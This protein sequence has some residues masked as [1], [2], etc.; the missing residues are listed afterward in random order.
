M[1][2][3]DLAKVDVVSSNLITRSIYFSLNLP[4]ENKILFRWSKFIAEE[5]QDE[6]ENKMIA[7]DVVY[8]VESL[9]KRKR[10]KLS[11]YGESRDEMEVLQARFGGGVTQVNPEDWQPLGV[12]GKDLLLR[13]RDRIVVTGSSDLARIEDLENANPGRTVLSFPPQLAF[14]TGSHPTSAGCLR[15]MVDFAKECEQTEKPWSVLDVGCG[16]GILAIAAAKLGAEKVVAIELDSMALEYAVIN[17]ERHGVADRIEFIDGDGIA[18]LRDAKN[19]KFD[20]ITANLFSELLIESMPLFRR[21][22][23]EN[24]AGQIILSGFL[25]SQAKDVIDESKQCGVAL[26]KFIRRGNWVVGAS[27]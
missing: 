16:S 13:I 6:W 26:K 22:L 14:G 17:A 7:A 12:E 27:D 23:T 20:L 3:R 10:L 11:S 2:E 25:T 21:N 1:V 4:V 9:V 15:L 24:P 18:L 5:Q 8:S 19:G